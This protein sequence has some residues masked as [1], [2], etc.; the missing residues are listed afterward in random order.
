M[1]KKRIFIYMSRHV[2]KCLKEQHIKL[3]EVSAVE[4]LE[5]EGDLAGVFDLENQ[6]F[7]VQL[8]PEAK[9]YFSFAVEKEDGEMQYYQYKVMG[10][11]F[12]PAVSAVTRLIKPVMVYLHKLDIRGSIYVDDGKCRD[13]SKEGAEVAMELM[14]QVIQ[15]AGWNIQWAKT[16]TQ[17]E[18]R[19]QYLGLIPDTKEME[20]RVE[21]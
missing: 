6:F 4:A 5:M 13:Q 2:N 7:H 8:H 9:K 18:Q 10:Y 17:V 16:T 11:G 21:E 1:V 20:F 14:L 12:A 3:D 19:V 15:L